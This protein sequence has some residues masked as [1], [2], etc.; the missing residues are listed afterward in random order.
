MRPVTAVDATFFPDAS[1][2]QMS[3]SAPIGFHLALRHVEH[4]I[5]VHADDLVGILRGGYAN[6]TDATDVTDGAASLGV[7]VDEGADKLEIG[8]FVDRSD[9]MAADGPRRPL[10]DTQL[11]EE[12]TLRTT[13]D[14]RKR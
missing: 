11:A 9:G 12:L 2:R 5:G 14:R 7:A 10:N 1:S 6:G 8:M 13:I 3:S 4:A